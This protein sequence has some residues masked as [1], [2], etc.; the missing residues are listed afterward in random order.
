MNPAAFDWGWS[1]F[2][3]TYPHGELTT[4]KLKL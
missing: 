1:P 4:P 2:D 3:M